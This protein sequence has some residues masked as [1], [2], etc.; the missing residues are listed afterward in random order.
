MA[1]NVAQKNSNS[2]PRKELKDWVKG[3][4]SWNHEDW[5]SLLKSLKSQG[6]GKWTDNE[7]GRTEL[8]QFLESEK[9]KA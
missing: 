5:L 8:G 3:R 1:N 7:K 6:Y 9:K 2:F 4:S